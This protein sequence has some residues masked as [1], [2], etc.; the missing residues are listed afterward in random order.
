MR[1]R[2]FVFAALAGIIVLALVFVVLKPFSPK[3]EVKAY[4]TNAEGLRAGAPVR[5][6][7]VGV[8]S[9]KSVRARPEMKE[10]PVEVVMVLNRQNDLNIPTDST[11]MLQADGVLGPTFVEIDAAGASGPP[12]SANS[13][14]KTQRV[15]VLTTDEIIEKLSGVLKNACKDGT[16][17]ESADCASAATRKAPKKNPSQ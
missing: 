15:T 2:A 1:W 3:V 6:A 7:G 16:K 13:V 17:E 4:F 9:V 8:G 5:L 14:L 11:V 12:I 10:T